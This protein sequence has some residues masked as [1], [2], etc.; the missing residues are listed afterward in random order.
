[1]KEFG[2]K[3][4]NNPRVL[5][6]GLGFLVLIALVD[7]TLFFLSCQRFASISDEPQKVLLEIGNPTD[8]EVIVVLTGDSYR[9]SE[10]LGLLRERRSPLLII[11]GAGIGITLT[12]LVNQQG[13]ATVD[14]H[15]T[16]KKIRVESRSSSTT[17]NAIE[18]IRILEEE[19]FKPGRMILVTSD[20]HMTR[21]RRIFLDA[22]KKYEISG[23]L[24]PY[25]VPSSFTAFTTQLISA[26][27]AAQR[28][29]L[30]YIKTLLY[31][32]HI[33]PRP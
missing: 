23:E 5:K 31:K 4:L 27:Q 25:P 6:I 15:R 29:T 1:M 21:A 22:K 26:R 3:F 30:E 17:E 7:I 2:Q 28:F 14:I 24:I 32:L 12:D 20:Y 18:T 11:S 16:W 33:L 10:A 9:I 13:S 8:D 19:Q